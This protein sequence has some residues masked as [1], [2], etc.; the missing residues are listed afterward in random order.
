MTATATVLLR[1]DILSLMRKQNVFHAKSTQRI[2]PIAL[3]AALTLLI[4]APFAVAQMPLTSTPMGFVA[5]NTRFDLPD[6]PGA[7]FTTPSSSADS[8]AA[9]AAS[10]D[11]GDAEF[12]GAQVQPTGPRPKAT[13]H[14]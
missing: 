10:T 6:S 12:D 1:G 4:E 7:L 14:L 3:A 13:P 11:P 9:D 5:A 2:L 8:N